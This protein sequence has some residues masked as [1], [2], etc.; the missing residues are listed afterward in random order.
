MRAEKRAKLEAA[1]YSV[2]TVAEF[3][4]LSP[5]EAEMVE[6]RVA[7]VNMAKTLRAEANLTQATLAAR[8]HTNQARI[9]KMEAADPGISTD[10]ILKALFALGASRKQV[11]QAIAA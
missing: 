9:A 8:I 3:L 6:M 11:A 10:F 7:L 2:G 5:S 1:G 4:Q